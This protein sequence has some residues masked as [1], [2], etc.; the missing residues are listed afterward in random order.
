MSRR[1]IREIA[2]IED[3]WTSFMVDAG[4]PSNLKTFL[5]SAIEYAEVAHGHKAAPR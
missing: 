2:A 3:A 1:A 5:A 4:G